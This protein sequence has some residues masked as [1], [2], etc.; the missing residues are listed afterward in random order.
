MFKKYQHT[1]NMIDSFSET[2]PSDISE[3]IKESAKEYI[4]SKAYKKTSNFRF[5]KANR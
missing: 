2:V 1:E 5:R 4:I 3:K